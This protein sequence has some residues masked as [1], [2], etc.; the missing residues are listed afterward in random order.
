MSENRHYA[1]HDVPPNRVLTDPERHVL[2][3]LAGIRYGSVEVLLHDGRIV[4]IERK[5]KLRFDQHQTL[6]R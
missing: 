2:D 5:E 3:A 6:G 4:Q 1:R